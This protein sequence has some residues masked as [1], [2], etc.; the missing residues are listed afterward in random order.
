MSGPSRLA[1]RRTKRARTSAR[2]GD[3]R[4]T[5]HHDARDAARKGARRSAR[6]HHC[7]VT[8]EHLTKRATN[9]SLGRSRMEDARIGLE[10][11]VSKPDD[12]STDLAPIGR[13]PDVLGRTGFR[14]TA[15][16]SSPASTRASDIRA[17]EAFHLGGV[18]T[19]NMAQEITQQR[20]SRSSTT[21]RRTRETPTPT[22][23]PRV[24]E[25]EAAAEK[26]R[27]TRYGE[28]ATRI[29]RP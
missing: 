7:E 18:S 9:H 28:P 2:R 23:A 14:R 11:F 24:R 19:A 22:A 16:W 21:N 15:E 8:K 29:A 3:D 26:T 13:W 17:S 27:G 4:W 12:I 25:A 1:A 10:R 5:N 20:G 6:S